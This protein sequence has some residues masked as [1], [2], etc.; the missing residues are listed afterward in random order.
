MIYKRNVRNNCNVHL[1]SYRVQQKQIP[2]FSLVVPTVSTTWCYGVSLHL[3][4]LLLYT[5]HSLYLAIISDFSCRF[6]RQHTSGLGRVSC[7]SHSVEY[8]VV[9]ECGLFSLLVGRSPGFNETSSNTIY[10]SDATTT[11]DFVGAGTKEPI[12]VQHND[13]EGIS[14]QI[15]ILLSRYYV[16]CGCNMDMQRH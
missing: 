16:T 3:N 11:C 8:I 9:D 2:A 14:N 10:T 1:C 12:V 6:I 5:K 15:G 7:E 13:V 4:L